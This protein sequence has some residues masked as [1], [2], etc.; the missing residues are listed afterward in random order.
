[1][2]VTKQSIPQAAT[3]KR[4]PF[5]PFGGPHWKEGAGG[6]GGEGKLEFAT[7]QDAAK[8]LEGEGY[9]VRTAE[10]ETSFQQQR[11]SEIIGNKTKEIYDSLD[12]KITE[13][14]GIARNDE[15]KTLDFVSRSFGSVS[16]AK[17]D[18]ETKLK[19]LQEKASKGDSLADEY[20]KQL[21]EVRG[22][23]KTKT[24]E[25]EKK[26]TEW[27]QGQFKAKVDAEVSS[28]FDRIK[29]T[30]RT[31]STF[32]EG[33]AGQIAYDAI[34]KKKIQDFRA[35]HKP[36]DLN[37]VIVWHDENDKPIVSQKDGSTKSTHELLE[38]TFKFMHAGASAAGGTGTKPAGSTGTVDPDGKN[39]GKI[40]LPPEVKTRV[41]LNNYIT[42]ELKLTG[43]EA[44]NV[45]MANMEALPLR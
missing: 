44:T 4:W 43:Q 2:T 5:S 7:V 23:L 13:V 6:G 33:E 30:L 42:K 1:M 32:G 19:D 15:E 37:G 11:E 12:S 36:V 38:S 17:S 18:L 29:D 40:D 39:K 16:T 22:T 35:S 20:K 34:V 31:A 14:T 9:I 8:H 45:Y 26:Q 24:E 21:A 41:D 10:Q 25:F 3:I 28:A 27:N